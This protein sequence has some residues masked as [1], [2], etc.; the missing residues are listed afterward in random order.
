[1]P[2]VDAYLLGHPQEHRCIQNIGGIANVTYLPPTTTLHWPQQVRGWDT[3]PGNSLLD[4]AAQRLSQGQL[5]YDADGAWAA[6]GKPDL[7]LV[8]RWLDHPYFRQ[9]PPKS[10]GRE[11]FGWD[12]LDQCLG[13][14]T[15]LTE[16]DF[17]ASLVELTALSIVRSYG[18]CLPQLPD[19][20]LLCGG[21]LHNGYLRSRLAHHLPGIPLE[22]TD[23][24]GV[25][26][27]FKE[28][29]A[30]AVLAH[31]HQHQQPGNLPAVTGAQTAVVLGEMAPKSRASIGPTGKEG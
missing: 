27:D 12:Y 8:H 4:L 13:E 18:D 29:I 5:S 14:A 10:T 20:V 25:N 2:P 1:M 3:G 15:H 22:S 17:L 30:F 24:A 31:W 16:A 26:A 7:S 21:G 19:R 11:L 23:T 28:A 6:Q 9:A